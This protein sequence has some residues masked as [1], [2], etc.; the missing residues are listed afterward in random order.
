VSASATASEGMIVVGVDGSRSSIEALE[1]A[2]KQAQLTGS[3]LRAVTTWEVPI[4]SGWVP[5]Y[6]EGYDPQ[7]AAE[8][9]LRRSIDE[10][11]GSEQKIAVEIVVTEGHPAPALLAAAADAQLLVVGSRG[12]R[13]FAGMLLGSVSWHCVVHATCPVVVV[14]HRSHHADGAEHAAQS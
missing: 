14:R 6:P 1:W 13:S 9:L 3:R 2:A 8:D 11:L 7:K 12:H 4:S 5:S 10:V